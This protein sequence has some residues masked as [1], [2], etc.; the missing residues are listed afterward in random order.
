[1]NMY[2]CDLC[3]REAPYATGSAWVFQTMIPCSTHDATSRIQ[4]PSLRGTVQCD[5]RT[6][7]P[8][9]KL[10]WINQKHHHFKRQMTADSLTSELNK[11]GIVS[12]SKHKSPFTCWKRYVWKEREQIASEQAYHSHFTHH[13][14]QRCQSDRAVLRARNQVI[15]LWST[16]RCLWL[17]PLQYEYDSTD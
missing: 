9:W 11:H 10:N 2:L 6:Q 16:K 3:R 4:T 7:R 13:M 12:K 5:N 1:M 14:P 17:M 8:Q 15:V